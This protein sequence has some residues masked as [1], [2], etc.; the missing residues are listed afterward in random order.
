[1]ERAARIE[2][3][4]KGP[5]ARELPSKS[6]TRL[7]ARYA[8]SIRPMALTDVAAVVQIHT[9]ALPDYF[10]TS[11]GRKFLALYYREVVR[12]KLGIS[13]VF[14]RDGRAVGFVTGEF[15]PGTFYRQIF[16]RRWF[17]FG[18]YALASVVRRLRILLRIVRELGNRVEAPRDKDVARL[19][20]LAVLPEFEGRGY[21]LALVAAAIEHIQ[22]HGATLVLLEVKQENQALI[23]AY[24]RMGFK[25]AGTVAKS[26]TE[27]LIKMTYTLSKG[28][29]DNARGE[30]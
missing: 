1:V 21:G 12:S 8:R 25:P 16:L 20:S 18:F 29:G 11:L 23:D 13:L 9:T 26:P 4:G 15:R 17:A 10:L 2:E 22:R 28:A 24:Q 6:L 19:A 27:T 3:K 7:Q 30:V 5:Q 14:V